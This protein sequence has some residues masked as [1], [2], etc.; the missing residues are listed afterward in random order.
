MPLLIP[1]KDI[2]KFFSY[3]IKKSEDECWE[4][5]GGKD[6]DGYGLIRALGKKHRCNRF[7]IMIKT[8]R[9]IPK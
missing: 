7:S 3:V 2:D 1:R 6:S 9:S 4:W 5:I 8:N